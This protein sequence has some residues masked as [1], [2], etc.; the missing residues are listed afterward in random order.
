VGFPGVVESYQVI[1]MFSNVIK[2]PELVK[3]YHG[4]PTPMNDQILK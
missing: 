3:V 1:K 4:S 2:V